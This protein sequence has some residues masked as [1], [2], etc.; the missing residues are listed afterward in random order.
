MDP[1]LAYINEPTTSPYV[2]GVN[3]DV[4]INGTSVRFYAVR[5]I[6]P[7]QELFVDYGRDYD[8]R[9]YDSAVVVEEEAEGALESPLRGGST[10]ASVDPPR[11]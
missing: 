8:R 2:G 5:D 1:T 10:G 7:G 9:D 6:M 11:K 4:D 3:V